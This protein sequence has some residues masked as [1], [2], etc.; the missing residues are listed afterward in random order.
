MGIKDNIIKNSKTIAKELDWLGQCISHRIGEQDSLPAPPAINEAGDSIYSKFVEY[1]KM[2]YVERLILVLVLA[3]HLRP[4]LFDVFQSSKLPVGTRTSLGGLRGTLHGGF[5]PTIQT[6]IYLV[7]GNKVSER[8]A[9]L[10]F[11]RS[12]HYFFKHHIVDVLHHKKDEPIT[13][14]SIRMTDEYL[15]YLTS[16]REYEPKYG[17]G[18]PAQRIKT[19]LDMED[20]VLSE[21]VLNEVREIRAWL[22]HRDELLND[23]GFSKHISA[24]YRALFYGP[25]GTGKSL[26]ASLLGR[27]TNHQVYRINLS[28][29]AS[30]YIGETEKKLDKLFADAEHRNWILF[31]DEADALFGKRSAT[32]EAKDRYANQEIAYLLQRIEHYSGVVILATNLKTNLDPAFARRFQSIIRFAVPDKSERLQLWEKTLPSKAEW[33]SDVDLESI[34]SDYELSG[35]GVVNILRYAA[36]STI[37][38]GKHQISQGAIMEGIRREYAKIGKTI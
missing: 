6:A 18:F 17:S 34:A 7:A 31:F 11:F 38:E 35:G 26:T 14:A 8:I 36:L 23:W 24:G 29:V 15:Y 1:Y 33:G 21:A 30:K 3:P 27:M 32:K 2:D 19:N 25:P 16:G 4:E 5:L 37:R 9:M 12:S 20:L 28:Q 10:D 22:E 13:T